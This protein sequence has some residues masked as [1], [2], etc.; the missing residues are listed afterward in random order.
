MLLY[1]KGLWYSTNL[2]N[3]EDI[4]MYTVYSKQ[5]CSSCEN[6]KELL[7]AKG[8]DFEV[9]MLGEDYSLMEMFEVAPRSHKTFPMILKDGEY[10]GGFD[11]LLESLQ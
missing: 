5:G 1:C 3:K 7:T 10:L 11:K 6:A 9:K 4:L 8:L 2:I